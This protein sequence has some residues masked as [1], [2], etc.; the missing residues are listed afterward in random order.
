MEA[1]AL[2]VGAAGRASPDHV[3]L[4]SDHEGTE[5]TGTAEPEQDPSDDGIAV[6]ELCRSHLGAQVRV[7]WG[8][9]V[10]VSVS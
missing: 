1:D 4:P 9:P 6:T 7:R 10:A 2:T 8:P 3:C 5:Q